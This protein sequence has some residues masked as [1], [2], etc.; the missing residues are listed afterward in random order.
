[1]AQLTD[2]NVFNGDDAV[3]KVRSLLDGFRCTMM[4]TVA[5]NGDVH[6]RPMGLQ[7]DAPD[8]EGTLWFFTSERSR[9]AH[10]VSEGAKVSLVF[11]NDD[12]SRYLQLNGEATVV[13]D[14]A[15]MRE[16]YSPLLKTWFPDGLDDP[17]L[18]LIRFD[19]HEGC[20]WD[21]PGGFTQVLGA[22]VKSVVTGRPGTGGGVGRVDL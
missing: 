15:K 1:M 8:F 11:Q 4:V 22:F 10:E 17:D 21:S 16:L 3:K 6:A 2:D 18:T 13:R 20:F 7:A 19:A 14:Q 5:P 12:Q 9:K